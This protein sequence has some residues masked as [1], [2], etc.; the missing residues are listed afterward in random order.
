MPS[1]TTNDRVDA[2]GDISRRNDGFKKL[3]IGRAVAGMAPS[4]STAAKKNQD[5][6]IRLRFATRTRVQNLCA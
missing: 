5:V 3:Q 1:I 4:L 2:N 6:P